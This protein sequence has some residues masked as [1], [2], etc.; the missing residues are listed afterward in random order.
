[1]GF[2]NPVFMF[3]PQLHV[4][5]TLVNNVDNFYMFIDDHMKKS[6]VGLATSWLI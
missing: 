6:V 5:I 4:E 1:M 2:H 3:F